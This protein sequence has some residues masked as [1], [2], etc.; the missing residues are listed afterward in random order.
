Y[1][2]AWPTFDLVATD[3]AEIAHEVRSSVERRNLD[4]V[5]ARYRQEGLEST[6]AALIVDDVEVMKLSDWLHEELYR[7]FDYRYQQSMPTFVATN[8]SGDALRN[9]L[10]DRIARRILDMTE[11]FKIA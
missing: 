5:V 1:L 11:P 8:L 9:H 10:G 2:G 4:A 3:G 7:I 6:R